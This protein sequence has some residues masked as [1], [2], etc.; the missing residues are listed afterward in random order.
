MVYYSVWSARQYL[1]K[2]ADKIKCTN[3]KKH[4]VKLV[5]IYGLMELM[6]DSSVLYSCGYF[7]QGQQQQIIETLKT[8]IK[9]IRPQFLSLIE[10]FDFD[11]NLITSSI[12]NQYGDIYE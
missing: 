7:K 12:G 6:K 5:T 8:Y 1:E 4:L 9:D 10:S 2:N 3:L 11:E